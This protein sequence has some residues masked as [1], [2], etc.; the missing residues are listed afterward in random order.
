MRAPPGV[1]KFALIAWLSGIFFLYRHIL[2]QVTSNAS[3][4]C[5]GVSSGL[6]A[7]VQDDV[8][9]I[10]LVALFGVGLVGSV[11]CLLKRSF[12]EPQPVEPAPVRETSS[13]MS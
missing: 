11:A 10:L 7:A 2:E 9:L 12:A 6:L 3:C 8:S 1:S 4:K 5:F 13:V